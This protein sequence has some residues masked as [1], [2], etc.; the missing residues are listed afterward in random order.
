MGR[1]YITKSAVLREHGFDK[2]LLQD[3]LNGPDRTDGKTKLYALERVEQA[4][5]TH[6]YKARQEKRN[7]E[8]AAALKHQAA[9]CEDTLQLAKR[10]EIEWK[11]QPPSSA[12]KA[13]QLGVQWSRRKENGDAGGKNPSKSDK[14]C[15][16]VNHIRHEYTNYEDAIRKTDGLPCE[17]EADKIIHGRCLSMIADRYRSLRIECERQAKM[18]APTVRPPANSERVHS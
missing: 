10:I 15:L 4:K 12:K 9:M 16:A 2:N 17:E 8:K 6:K 13:Y 1:K 5:K 18:K 7:R 14:N 3:L 11:G